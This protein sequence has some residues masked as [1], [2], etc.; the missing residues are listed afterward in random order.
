MGT[1][2][3]CNS[4]LIELCKFR[5]WDFQRASMQLSSS[6]TEMH[7]GWSES[8]I[9]IGPQPCWLYDLL[10][11][12]IKLRW[13]NGKA[14][15]RLQ[16]YNPYSH[17]WLTYYRGWLELLEHHAYTIMH[18]ACHSYTGCETMKVPY[19]TPSISSL[20][21]HFLSNR[22]PSLYVK[23]SISYYLLPINITSKDLV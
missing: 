20:V 17:S 6:L 9:V 10:I 7:A 5:R 12:H 18:A 2:Q 21:C 22:H 15:M 19:R 1:V 14:N 3:Y 16:K 8:V 4:V 11:K 13:L 23:R